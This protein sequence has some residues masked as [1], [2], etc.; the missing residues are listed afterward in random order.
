MTRRNE[1][2]TRCLIGGLVLLVEMST[3]EIIAMVRRSKDVHKGPTDRRVLREDS[4]EKVSILVD[5]GH[6][7]NDQIRSRR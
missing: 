5:I 2:F 7:R 6:A 3:G 4:K 1:R